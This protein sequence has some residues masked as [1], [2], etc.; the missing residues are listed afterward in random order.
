M[1]LRMV[2]ILKKQL[3][4]P[5]N[6]FFL[7]RIERIEIFKHLSTELHEQLSFHMTLSKFNEGDVLSNPQD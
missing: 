1:K 3:Q 2:Q 4:N 6:S 7:N 5:I